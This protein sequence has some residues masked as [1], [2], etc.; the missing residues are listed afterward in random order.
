MAA[1]APIQPKQSGT[2]VKQGTS[3][4]SSKQNSTVVVNQF[5][6]TNVNASMIS[7]NQ[8]NRALQSEV[9]P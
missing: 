8:A 7:M 5:A 9:K 3:L 6:K 1:P 4:L 2:T